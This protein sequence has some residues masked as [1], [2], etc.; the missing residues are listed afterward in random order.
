[1]LGN[2]LITTYLKVRTAVES[3]SVR[4]NVE[5]CRL[6][7]CRKLHGR[8]DPT[9]RTQPSKALDRRHCKAFV[10]V[11]EVHVLRNSTPLN[12][13]ADINPRIHA[14]SSILD[15]L[16]PHRSLGLYRLAIAEQTDVHEVRGD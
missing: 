11:V 6:N 14:R 10:V 1:M 12:H 5:Q 2:P 13:L 9:L 4:R 7:H 3:A 15:N 16:I 8:L